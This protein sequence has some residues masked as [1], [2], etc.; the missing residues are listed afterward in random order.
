MKNFIKS[1]ALA[2]T[3]GMAATTSQ[4][5]TLTLDDD[6][7]A[8]SFGPTSF[9]E[10]LDFTIVS[11]AFLL[12]TDAFISG[13]VFELFDGLTSLGQT[14]AVVAD[15][16]IQISSDYQ[17]AFDS[18][19]YSSGVFELGAGTYTIS[20]L[21][22]QNASGFTSGGAAA[23][24]SSTNP[25]LAAVPLPAAGWFLIESPSDLC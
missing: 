16:G 12:V 13:D 7:E 22:T 17:G 10:T 9:D 20:G 24:L 2:F 19:D 25:V 21:V 8:F 5:V 1:T 14:S 4:A 23:A 6:F 18:V 3:L 11:T 15:A